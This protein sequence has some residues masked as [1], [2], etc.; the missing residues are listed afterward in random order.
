MANNLQALMDKILS[1][2]VIHQRNRVVLP[3]LVNRDLSPEPGKKGDTINVPIPP[4]LA[5]YNVTPGVSRSAGND[6]TT[7]T[8]TPVVLDTWKANGFRLTD[9]DVA[10]INAQDKFLPMATQEAA[11]ALIDDMN[12]SIADRYKKIYGFSGT[13]GQTP[14]QRV[15]PPT[16]DHHDAF[17]LSAAGGVLN[18][19]KATQDPRHFVMSIAA[20]T[21]AQRIDA[22]RHADKLGD[23]RVGQRAQLGQLGGF[24]NFWQHYIPTH[25]AGSITGAPTVTGANA[26]GVKVINLT[27]GVAEAV[28]FVEGDIITFAGDTQTYTVTDALGVTIGASSTGNVNIEPGLKV[29]TTGGEAVAVKATHVVNLAFSPFCFAFVMRSPEE[30]RISGSRRVMSTVQ[31]PVT[32][33]VLRLELL[34][35]HKQMYWELDALWG[36]ACTHPHL[37]CRAAG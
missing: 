8:T 37:G 31:D 35:E 26:I 16:L 23:T 7:P 14:F 32:G 4:A 18:E 5:T 25:T 10:E 13:P 28:N 34:D 24:N 11:N 33:L 1:R 12:Q 6:D 29:A 15:D 19:Q 3:G 30:M 36:T 9:K 2:V 20:H 21:N 22:F 17:I 27:T